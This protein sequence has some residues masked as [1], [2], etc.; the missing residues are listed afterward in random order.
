MNLGASAPSA[1]A[2]M[3]R[4]VPTLAVLVAACGASSAGNGRPA[5][6][7]D[8]PPGTAVE[9]EPSAPPNGR[10]LR[11]RPLP[12]HAF[13]PAGFWIV[14][15]DS[16]WP[17][18][19]APVDFDQELVLIASAGM[20]SGEGIGVTRAVS[21]GE[22]IHVTVVHSLPGPDCPTLASDEW[23]GQV[24]AVERAEGPVHLHVEE[25]RNPPCLD[26]PTASLE[27]WTA[28]TPEQRAGSVRSIEPVAVH[29]DASA[30]RT[31]GRSE[32][33]RWSW[34]LVTI[35]EGSELEEGPLGEGPEVTVVTDSPGTYAWEVTVTDAEGNQST[36]GG[37]A[38]IGPVSRTFD[39]TAQWESQDGEPVGAPLVIEV[40]HGDIL[41]ALGLEPAPT[42]CATRALGPPPGFPSIV[43]LPAGARGRFRITVRYPEGRPEHGQ[44]KITIAPDGT[45]THVLR[46]DRPRPA[47]SR[48]PIGSVTM[49]AG[50]FTP[51]D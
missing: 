50:S 36:A 8:G 26:A 30:S 45:P 37:S 46:D 42:W 14:R 51:V 34:R 44:A 2:P 41:C 19:G 12:A 47:G 22:A 17:A 1:L 49:P 31:D 33:D 6:E 18:D 40:R 15:D 13:A 11:V 16:E 48:W 25:R 27:C 28:D 21:A 29:C 20:G 32:P 4:S 24:V 35:P 9:A 5:G 23:V 39:V 3:L 38:L 10:S 43:Q 7:P